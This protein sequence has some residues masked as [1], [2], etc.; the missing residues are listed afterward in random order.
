MADD[1]KDSNPDS[2]NDQEENEEDRHENDVSDEENTEEEQGDTDD[3]DEDTGLENQSDKQA[4]R[5]NKEEDEDSEDDEIEQPAGTV[6]RSGRVSKPRD[7]ARE[8]PPLFFGSG[9][10]HLQEAEIIRTSDQIGHWVKPYYHNDNLE[11]KLAHGTFYQETYFSKNV[12]LTTDDLAQQYIEQINRWS[13]AD[14]Y[15]LYTEALEWLNFDHNEITG[16]MFKVE[17]MSVQKGIEKYG[18]QGK[19]SALKEIKNIAVKNKCFKE[20]SYESLTQEMKD[21]ALPILMFMV[22]K[23]NGDIKTRGCANGSFQRVYTNKDECS[24]P[25][26]DFFAFKYICAIIALEE[27]DV[28]TVDL[29][30]FFLQTEQEEGNE[31]LILK[32]I[33]AVAMLLVEIDPKRWR[34]HLW[35][36][37]DKWVIYVICTKAIYGTMNAALLAYK[38]LARLF[39][40]WGMIMNPYDPCVWNKLVRLKQLT[41]MFHIDDLLTSHKRP[42]VVTEYIKR[43]TLEYGKNDDLT[44][45]R[46]KIHEYLGQTVNWT[47]KCK[48]AIYQYDFIKKFW[49][50]LLQDFK[51]GS[52]MTP[53]PEYLFK[54]RESDV[55]LD[56]TRKEQ[57]HSMAAKCLWLSQHSQNDMQLA[58]GFHCTRVK[59]PGE[60]NWKKMKWLLQYMWSTRWIPLIIGIDK[61]GDCI[62]YIDGAHAVHPDM[63]GHGGMFVTMGTGAM[64]SKSSK[65]KCNTLSST[66]TELVATGQLLPRATWFRYFRI[67]QGAPDKEDLLLQDNEKSNIKLQK[68]FPYSTGSATKHINVRYFFAVDKNQEKGNQDTIL[69]HQGNDCRLQQQTNSRGVVCLPKGPVARNQQRRYGIVQ[70]MVQKFIRKI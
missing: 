36:E 45:T 25:T 51:S 39:Y 24:S 26:P 37:L 10:Q 38:K 14:Q 54:V 43:L 30:G 5:P 49:N 9:E 13:E 4:A 48:C 11:L 41:V 65:L 32:L 44:V 22:M 23:R 56:Q 70:K 47:I 34:K 57:Y 52:R 55:K 62:I 61:K 8:F 29:P 58:T 63:K 2:D 46:G 59:E 21:K 15:Q 3:A 64:M 31:K 60:D 7:L 16:M 50:G 17:Q 42:E 68:I 28:A 27:R 53:A 33:G 40:S 1:D 20:I 69:S 6:T 66:E 12:Q 35:Q 18:K 19:E 67:A